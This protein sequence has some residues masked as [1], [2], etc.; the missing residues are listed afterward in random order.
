MFVCAVFISINFVC[1]EKSLWSYVPFRN[2][3]WTKTVLVVLLIHVAYLL[4]QLV[5]G[6]AAGEYFAAIPFHFWIPTAAWPALLIALNELYK[7]FEIK[8]IYIIV[9]KCNVV[10]VN[11]G[12][13]LSFKENTTAIQEDSTRL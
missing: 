13:C 7:F 1:I 10:V 12:L 2:R 3:N 5:G 11:V 8:Y 4:E 6:E 9:C